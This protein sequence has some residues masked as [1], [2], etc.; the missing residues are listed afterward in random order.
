MPV[1]E[2]I[3]RF[4]SGCGRFTL[5]AK[6]IPA[7]LRYS[8]SSIYAPLDSWWTTAVLLDIHGSE[9]YFG[10]WGSTTSR[11]GE[12]LLRRLGEYNSPEEE[13]IT[14]MRK[15]PSNCLTEPWHLS[16][17]QFVRCDTSASQC[18]PGDEKSPSGGFC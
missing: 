1:A 15:Q 11:A 12:V 6:V 2:H 18:Q 14:S 5:S 16:H 3:V 8:E 9:Y 7:Q 4:V 17:S 10:G 13:W